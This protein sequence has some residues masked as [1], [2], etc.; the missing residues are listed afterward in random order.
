MATYGLWFRRYAP[1]KRF[2]DIGI[3]QFE[4]DDRGP[5]TSLQATSRTYAC[6]MFDSGG[7]RHSFANSSGTTFFPYFGTPFTGHSNV[8]HAVTRMP[9]AGP[10]LLVFEAHSEGANPLVP[11]SPDIDTFVK[12]KIDFLGNALWINGEAFGDNFPALEIFLYS[13]RS[14]RAA[15]LFDGRTTGGPHEG[16]AKRLFSSHRN[17]SLGRFSAMLMLDGSGELAFD[18]KAD[19]TT[20][21]N[22]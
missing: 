10:G 6:V 12:V 11:K 16:P 8:R 15:M 2:G 18:Y 9:I 22:Y 13:Y 5:S 4:G 3:G 21:P 7:I 1:F 14:G 19:S 20:M 17:H